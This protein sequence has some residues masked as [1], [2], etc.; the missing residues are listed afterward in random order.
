MI[1]LCV[2]GGGYW[3]EN[4][5][6]TLHELGFLAG[7]VDIENSKRDKAKKYPR[8]DTFSDI[9]EA[10]KENIFD[11]FIIASPV[12]THFEIEKNFATWQICS[13]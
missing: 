9:E 2:V 10:L 13:N 4:H 8:I 5:L 12:A 6:K 1:K 11:G 7:L 3:G